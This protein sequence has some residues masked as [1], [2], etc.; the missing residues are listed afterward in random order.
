MRKTRFRHYLLGT[1]IVATAALAF[2]QPAVAYAQ[3]ERYQL[4]IPAQDLGSALRAFASVARQQL[5]FDDKDV[6]GKRAP[7][8]RGSYTAREALDRLLQDSGLHS[9]VGQSGLFIIRPVAAGGGAGEL[10]AGQGPAE[11]AGGEW[12]PEEIIVTGSHI[13]GAGS[14]AGSPVI[15]ITRDEIERSGYA[16]AQQIVQSLP[17]NYSGGVSEDTLSGADGIRNASYNSGVNL[18]GLGSVGTLV[19]LNGRRMSG[20]TTDGLTPDISLIPASAIERVEILPDGASAVYGSDAVAGVVNF[21]LRDNYA[22]AET[23]LRYGFDTNGSLDEYQV[24]QTI[25]LNWRTGNLLLAGE[26]YRRG[27]LPLSERSFSATRDLRPKGGSDWRS[28]NAVPGN[29]LDETESTVLFAIPANQDGRDL[30]LADLRPPSEANR[31]DTNAFSDVLPRQQ[32]N[33][34]FAR[35]AQE[36]SPRVQ[37][38]GE[39]FYA[40]RRY[41]QR[42]S[43]VGMNVEVPSTNPF[44]LDVFGDGS[45]I[46]VSYN[47]QNDRVQEIDAGKLEMYQVAGGGEVDLG[48]RWHL[49]VHG[50]HSEN[51]HTSTSDLLDYAALTAALADPDPNTA[52]NVFGNGNANNPQTIRSIFGNTSKLRYERSYSSIQ[53]VIDGPLLELPGG[54]LKIAVGAEKSIARY[55]RKASNEDPTRAKRHAAAAFGEIL[56]PLVGPE[57]SLSGIRGL[58]LSFSIRTEK[59]EDSRVEPVPARRA[60]IETTNPKFGV[61][62]RVV[63]G[64]SLRGS[65]GTAFRVPS[66]TQLAAEKNGAYQTISDPTSP[67]GNVRAVTL[68]GTSPNLTNE[69]A[70]TWTIGAEV[71]PQ[72]M[73]GLR[74]ELTY[75]QI[76][77][78]NR[79]VNFDSV[80]DMIANS[81]RYPGYAVRNPNAAQLAD[82]CSNLNISYIPP[83]ICVSPESVDILL[84]LRTSN[85][86]MTKTDGVD[87]LTSYAWNAGKIGDFDWS[88]NANYIFN[89]DQSPTASALPE[90]VLNTRSNPIDL[91]VRTSLT[92]SHSSGI[93]VS[94]S[95]NYTDSY[96][97]PVS[98]PERKIRSHLTFDLT[99]SIQPGKWSDSG[100]L[101]DTLV[102]FSVLNVLDR[103]PPFL[104]DFLGYDMSNGDPLGRFVS[105]TVTKR[106]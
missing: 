39:L 13:R 81:E 66:L 65:Y 14:S 83:E 53:A 56:L 82:A 12:E 91:H 7:A 76:S 50:S 90:S 63:K 87:F 2:A 74:A 23:R 97:D 59:Y 37:I 105:L 30:T 27:N 106:W 85:R 8:L 95:A 64:L 38:F 72:Q 4:D 16:S 44:Y 20:A 69:K 92:W 100:I 48:R 84:D 99:A 57:N 45:P 5:M 75:Y 51:T 22:G 60:E 70:K 25:G 41:R 88:M 77:F 11:R 19:L 79:I 52:L 96:R 49:R 47:F 46:T 26:Y 21:I 35:V 42:I 104:D 9:S 29:I 94:T 101:K 61:N 102:S 78:R 40:D 98:R 86:A 32:R 80:F 6:L 10:D 36:I 31:Y 67:N 15:S 3:E 71:A 33:S 55:Y 34:A 43:G 28:I 17:Q 103:D 54:D 73:P 18:R 62:W 93:T 68:F 1:S 89:F 24:S 58:D